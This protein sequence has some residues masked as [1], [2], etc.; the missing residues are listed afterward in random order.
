MGDGQRGKTGGAVDMTDACIS[1][2]AEA[3][4]CVVTVVNRR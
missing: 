3:K 2:F 1:G 4:F